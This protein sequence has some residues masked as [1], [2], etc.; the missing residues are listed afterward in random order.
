MKR[1]DMDEGRRESRGKARVD[2]SHEQTGAPPSHLRLGRILSASPEPHSFVELVEADRRL[3][4]ECT[5]GPSFARTARTWLEQGPPV[6]PAHPSWR[7]LLSASLVDYA[8]LCETSSPFEV[9]G[10]DAAEFDADDVTSSYRKKSLETHPDRHPAEESTTWRHRQSAVNSAYARIESEE[11]WIREKSHEVWR[12][13][14]M[15]RLGK[16]DGPSLDPPTPPSF[17]YE[18]PM[19]P[20]WIFILVA[21]LIAVLITLKEFGRRAEQP[22]LASSPP[23]I[24]STPEEVVETSAP[25][26]PPA[27]P[28]PRSSPAGPRT[29]I[30]TLSLQRAEHSP[31]ASVSPSPTATN[32]PSPS[33]TSTPRA[34][35]A[36]TPM[37]VATLALP[38]PLGTPPR[39]IPPRIDA[40]IRDYR[41]AVATGDRTALE[42]LLPANATVNNESSDRYAAGFD[43]FARQADAIDY[44]LDG[45]EWESTS[46]DSITVRAAY[47][48]DYDWSVDDAVSRREQRGRI[49]WRFA[50]SG[51]EWSLTAMTYDIAPSHGGR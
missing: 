19:N 51:G 21:G 31:V 4:G 49:M 11:G 35:P 44:K 16:H 50:K 33:P 24:V 3:F 8:K 20:L 37:P 36:S 40:W 17:D 9:L 46:N 30:A 23:R 12:R 13:E 18:L 42:R 47:R 5:W 32:S 38:K 10:I 43:L 28:S 2:P 26:Q 41:A 39:P 6:L 14:V 15:A 34:R 45:M 1:R 27:S 48:L 22:I 7:A 25:T 29:D